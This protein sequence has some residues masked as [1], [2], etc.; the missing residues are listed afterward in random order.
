[1]YHKKSIQYE[2]EYRTVIKKA[3]I[4]VIVFI[5]FILQL[6]PMLKP[7]QIEEQIVH[8]IIIVEDIPLTRQTSYR[9]PPPKPAVPIP[10]EEESVPEDETIEE[11]DL[12]L[13]LY[14]NSPSGETGGFGSPAIIPPRPIVETIP[15]YPEE[16]YKNGVTGKVKLHIHVDK[17]GK[18]I[19]VVVLEN[20]T[21]SSRCEK[22]AI[23]AAFQCRYISARQGNNNV[24][25]W[26]TRTITY[27]IPQ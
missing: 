6:F 4:I 9:P 27:E 2:S 13:D 22:A 1:M 15:E 12:R 23:A 24:N 26:I 17:S 5:I 7:H 10:S 14:S 20:T 11:T 25:S 16:D 19:D 18:V 3:L 8:L 21:K